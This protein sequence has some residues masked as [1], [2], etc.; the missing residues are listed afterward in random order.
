MKWMPDG[1]IPAKLFFSKLGDL[2][3]TAK[4]EQLKAICMRFK[5]SW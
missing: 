4:F 2:V 1:P 5:V 3:P